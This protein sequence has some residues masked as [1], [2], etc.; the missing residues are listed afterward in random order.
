MKTN[1]SVGTDFL[2]AGFFLVAVTIV[3]G[4]AIVKLSQN[5]NKKNNGK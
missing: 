5:Y 3:F 4:V 1:T 2:K